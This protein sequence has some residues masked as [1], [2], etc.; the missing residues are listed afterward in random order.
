MSTDP[1]PGGGNPGDHRLL[2]KNCVYWEQINRN[3]RA[4]HLASFERGPGTGAR[5]GAGVRG[6]RAGISDEARRAPSA[7]I[8]DLGSRKK[9]R[10]RA[11]VSSP[12]N[13]PHT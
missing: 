3:G 6:L 7:Q 4:K 9:A 13:P 8:Q 12:G 11:G 1:G 5:A 2:D 10:S